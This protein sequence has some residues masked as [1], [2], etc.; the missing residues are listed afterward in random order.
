VALQAVIAEQSVDLLD[1]ELCLWIAED[2]FDLG[3]DTAASGLGRERLRFG[4]F[5]TSRWARAD[6]DRGCAAL[7][8]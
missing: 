8:R 3:G 6:G 4:G 1:R 2:R 5:G 7:R